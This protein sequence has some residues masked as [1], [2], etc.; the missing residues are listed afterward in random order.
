[1]PTIETARS[2]Y[3]DDPVHGFDHVLRVYYLAIR[4]AQAEGADLEIV[5]TAAL[6]HD[7]PRN[8][9]EA[10]V[11]EKQ[12]NEKGALREGHHH[13]AARF[14]QQVLESEGWTEVR[15]AA[16]VHCIETHRF[17]DQHTQP[18]TLEAQVLF[19][20]D[21][22][23]AIGA[24]GVARAIAY[25]VK[26][27]QP[28]YAPPSAEFLRSGQTQPGE[29]HSSYHEH[30]FKLRKLKE[31]LYTR[32]GRTLALGRHDFLETFYAQLLAEYQGER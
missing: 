16:V 27:G 19:D 14:A 15:I 6:L 22:L 13:D 31:R 29:P 1:M 7:V 4:L 10:D 12:A 26:H 17:R 24:T 25:A 3:P 11:S 30:L 2:W 5:R 9:S 20:A 23:D 21:K 8:F 18:H 28:V 32:T